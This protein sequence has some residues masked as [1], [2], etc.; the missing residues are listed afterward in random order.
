MFDKFCDYMYYLLTSPFK[1]VKKSINQWYILF[2]VLGRRFDDALESLYNAEE[3]TMLA[4]CEPE[5]L[6][7]HA[8]DRK[9]ARYPGEEDE[10]FRARIA[11]YP[12][13]L[14][15]GGSDPGVL[16]AVRTLG[17]ATPELVKAN[18]FKGRVY[19]QTD[20]TWNL[21]GSRLLEAGVLP[22]RWAEFY[23]VIKMSV[24]E[25]HPIPTAI[26]KK[27]V[28][29][30]KQVGAKD[31]YSF[32]YSLSIREPHDARSRADYRWKL[33]YWNYRML[34]GTW[35]LDGGYLLDSDR[36]RYPVKIGFRYK[37]FMVFP[38]NV[39]KLNERF[40][41]HIREPDEQIGQRAVF[42]IPLFYWDYR[43]TD[44]SWLTD[45][46]CLLDSDR[47]LYKVRDGY[48]TS[49]SHKEEIRQARMHRQHNLFYLDGSWL[50]DGSRVLDAWGQEIIIGYD[51]HYL[52]GT[53]LQDG[54]IILDGIENQ[55]VM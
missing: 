5:M 25:S 20:G 22:D 34:D 19:Y 30:T 50:T 12:E 43:K 33:F 29:K 13:V 48:R 1:R 47:T 2:R 52:D 53:W 46:S 24:D 38:Y 32:Q 8:E 18:E 14:R 36:S 11:N 10:N 21:D 55:E 45:G 15:L 31:N 39:S 23:I 3:Q 54:D 51:L 17:Y 35:N 9:M 27:E 44:G 41:I 37:G 6:P 40:E 42:H 7:V 16:L 26:L 28:R 4:T 49:I